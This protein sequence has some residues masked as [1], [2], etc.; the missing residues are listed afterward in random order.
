LVSRVHRVDPIEGILPS[1]VAAFRGR[2]YKAD[3]SIF[4]KGYKGKIVAYLGS[5]GIEGNGLAAEPYGE[6][7]AAAE[8]LVGDMP[9]RDQYRLHRVRQK[10]AGNIGVVRD[11]L[12]GASANGAL[13]DMPLHN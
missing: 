4:E 1:R 9:S 7:A 13:T 11:I 12:K 5:R 8:E 6:Y 3:Y 2:E 10:I